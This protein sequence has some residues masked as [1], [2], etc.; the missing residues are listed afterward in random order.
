MQDL[1][2]ALAFWLRAEREAGTPIALA[3]F[4]AP[5]TAAILSEAL[6]PDLITAVTQFRAMPVAHVSEHVI[7]ELVAD[8][9]A[10]SGNSGDAAPTWPHRRS[11]TC[12]RSDRC[13]IVP[14]ARLRS[15]VP[16]AWLV[17][18]RAVPCKASD[19]NAITLR[20]PR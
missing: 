17:K 7:K 10:P 6:Q 18:R 15:V 12:Q 20:T 14:I 13:T 19:A 1:A 8:W 9:L 2:N 5:E 3:V 16:A 11:K 4:V